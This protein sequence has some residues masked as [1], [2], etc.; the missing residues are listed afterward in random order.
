[1]KLENIM[2]VNLIDLNLDASTK[3]E[4]ITKIGETLLQYH[5]I[6]NLEKFI[7]DVY[8]RE[9]IE[10]TNLVFGIAIPHCNSNNNNKSSVSLVRMV[11]S[12]D[13][14][15]GKENVKIIFLL[16]VA[17]NQEGVS[18]L[19]VIAGIATLL[20]EDDFNELILNTNNKESI[21]QYISNELGGN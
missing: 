12:V 10:S 5:R 15:D 7:E 18:H 9:T 19:E 4:A 3:L 21:L 6:L 20:I 1:M 11:N 14:E 17:P 2:N 8:Q 16:S 13:W